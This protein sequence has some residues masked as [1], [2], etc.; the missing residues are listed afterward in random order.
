M[1]DSIADTGSYKCLLP[2]DLFN[3]LYATIITTD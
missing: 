1:R 2:T 3:E